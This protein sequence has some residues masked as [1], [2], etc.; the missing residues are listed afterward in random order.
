MKWPILLLLSLMGSTILVVDSSQFFERFALWE[1]FPYLTFGLACAVLIE[2]F[3]A[4]FAMLQPQKKTGSFLDQPAFVCLY[5]FSGFDLSP[6]C[7]FARDRGA[8]DTI[9]HPKS[10]S[11]S[12]RE[13]II[14]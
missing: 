3:V 11:S 2:A 5:N 10:Y 6:E 8:T 13:L 1:P 7:D 12:R 14:R 4:T 9:K